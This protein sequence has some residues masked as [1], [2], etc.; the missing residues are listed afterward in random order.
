MR[1][2]AHSMPRSDRVLPGLFAGLLLALL[3][4]CTGG[5]AP[6]AP[7]S[8][9]ESETA[10]ASEEASA[11]SQ[12]ASA[13]ASEGADGGAETVTITGTSFN[14][15]EI[16]V[17]AGDTVTFVND[18]ALP[19]TVTEGTDGSEADGARFNE[20]LPAGDSVEITFDQAGDAN[21]TCLFHPNMNMVVHVQ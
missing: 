6:S 16:T 18:S 1:S 7:A 21:V 13:A 19:H 4:G 5:G 11:A 14:T 17:T 20:Q 10:S 3:V 12:E 2:V 9:P 15:T 8:A